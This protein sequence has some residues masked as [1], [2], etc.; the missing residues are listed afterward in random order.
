[1][2]FESN[3]DKY[4]DCNGIP[5]YTRFFNYNPANPIAILL[6][7]HRADIDRIMPIVTILEPNFNIIAFDLPGF[8]K[9]KQT[10]QFSNYIQ[11]CTK[12]LTYVI[13][14]LKL[15]TKEICLFGMSQGANIIIEYVMQNPDK[16]FKRLGLI[17][18]IFSYKY[19]SMR[20]FYKIF[21]DWLTTNLGKGKLFA[22]TFQ[23][24][25]DN[26][27]LFPALMMMF[28]WEC[29][30]NRKVREYEKTQWKLMTMQ[31]W[32]ITLKHFLA[33]DYTSIK[34]SFNN[35]PITF[36]YPKKDQ[37]LDIEQSVAGFRKMFPNAEFN[38]FDS[39]KHIPRGNFVENKEFMESMHNIVHILLS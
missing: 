31:H 4:I 27:Y 24:G 16:G 25:M 20:K 34:K 28:D 21:V 38:Y 3:T 15:D 39:Q 19:L 6:N 37:Y 8:G 2:N 22:K 11:Y 23:K 33:I 30:T 36:V 10:H 12:I 13:E 5:I 9:S 17:A 32:G 1:M 14:N 26:K 18:P 29:L 35:K 7:G